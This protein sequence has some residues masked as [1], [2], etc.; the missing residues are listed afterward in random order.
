MHVFPR[1]F[2]L[3][4]AQLSVGGI[5]S[6]SIPPFHEIQRGYYK[7]SAFVYLLL[8]ALALGGRLTLWVG[9]GASTSGTDLAE[10]CLWSAFV[11]CG[12]GYFAT[13]WGE[14]FALRARLFTATW[15]AGLA[16]LIVAAESYATAPILSVETL[17]YPTTFVLSALLLGSV[18]SGMLLGHWY[19]IDRNLSLAPLWTILRFY[20]ACLGIQI[21]VFA[22]G[23]VALALFGAP[24]SSAQVGVLLRN[25]A[26]LLG[27]RVLVS[28][29]G[30]AIL[31]AMI[32]RTLKI[33][34][35]MAA[36]G[37]FYIAVLAVLVGEFMGRYLLFRTGL[38]L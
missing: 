37:L 38:P 22:V 30:A 15:G 36:T 24:A 26:A 5:L 31:G 6:L 34:Q 20:L 28:P 33:P 32:W 16:A 25:E 29:V 10:I 13:L 3:V 19:L 4:F 11:V 12:G 17:L 1:S 18:A 21:A 14:R 35:T 8:G 27:A 7:S 9:A 2:L 23:T